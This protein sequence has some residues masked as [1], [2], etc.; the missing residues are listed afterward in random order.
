MPEIA[1]AQAILAA[2]GML[3]AQQNEMSALT[4]LALCRLK[5][6]DR[7]E[8]AQRRSLTISKGIMTFVRDE[9]GRYYA[10]N[11]R[12]TFR[13]QVLHQF[14]QAGIVDYNPDDP[15]LPTNSPNAHYAI[16][17]EALAVIHAYGTDAWIPTLQ[18]FTTIRPALQSQ[19]ARSAAGIPVILP[20]GLSMALSPGKHNMLQAQVIELFAPR[21]ASGAVLLY[22]GDTDKKDFGSGSDRVI[23]RNYQ[24]QTRD[25]FTRSILEP[26]LFCRNRT[27]AQ[28]K[29]P[30]YCPR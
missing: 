23:C 4:L 30:S 21:F 16:S 22:L 27:A 1:Q 2:I 9:Y 25:R 20:D 7:W 29:Y 11:T 12:E 5:P 6:N 15:T 8:M 14:V 26:R 13:R 19:A 3:P 18:S 28:F 17:E 10:P 24:A